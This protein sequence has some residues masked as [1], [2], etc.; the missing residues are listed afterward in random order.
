[1]HPPEEAR[2]APG[3]YSVLFEDPDGLRLD[4][5]FVPRKGNLASDATLPLDLERITRNS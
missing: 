2:W 1:V 3:Y 5:N 4:A